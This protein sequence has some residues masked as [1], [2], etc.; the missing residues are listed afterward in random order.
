M[1]SLMSKCK[2]DIKQLLAWVNEAQQ[3]FQGWRADSWEDYE[4]RDGKQ[5]TD[6][7]YQRMAS[8]G[9]KPLTIN[10]TFPIMNLVHG[11]FLN[12]QRDIVA[13][14]RTKKD[15]ELGQVMSEGIQFVVDQ[16][17][18]QQRMNRAVEQQLTA[19]FGC[20]SVGFSNDPRKEKV[21]LFSHNWYSMWWDPY[22]T[23]W[24]DKEECRY[25][26]SAEWTDFQNLI[27]L[28]PEKERE[29]KD[30]F[31]NLATDS[32]VPDVYDE[33]T[34]VEDYKKYLSSSYWVNEERKRVR[35]IEMWYPQ[36]QKTFF[37][38]MPNGRVI[39]LDAID[40]LN[41]EYNVITQAKEVVTANVKKMR[42][43]T[44][45]H[46][47]LL[48]D[49][50]SPYAH[51]EYPFVPFVGYLDRYDFPF[52]IPRQIKEQDME[53]NKRRS[54]A[55][56]LLNSRRVI[57]EQNATE[58][59]Q[60][61]HAEA[62]RPDGFVVMKKGKLDK[63]NIK[64]MADLAPAQMSMMTQSEQEMRE[65]AGAEEN[66]LNLGVAAQSGVALDK[67]QQSSA[68]MTASL[69]QNTRY[70]QRMLGERI[71]SLIQNTWTDE[72]VLRITDRV[73]GTEKFVTLNER[74]VEGTG[75]TVK[76]DITQATFD[77]KVTDRQMTDT[78][79]EKNMDLIFTAINK[80]PQEAVGPLLNLAL[81][82]SDI[83]DKDALLQQ[84]RQSTGVGPLNDDLTQEERDAVA[85]QEQEAKR[86]EQ[87]KETQQADIMTALDQDEK[88]AKAELSRAKA[89]EA[90]AKAAA[91]QQDVDQSGYQIGVQAAQMMKNNQESIKVKKNNDTTKES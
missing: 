62:N 5:W 44:F 91:A 20:M 85:T 41:E 24:M 26:F 49:C 65:I 55:L 42:V 87:E 70:S 22:A 39:D 14:G 11:H 58:D 23:P 31:S 82:L 1:G 3:S 80:S 30:Q 27:A 18:G 40:D 19:G 13:K 16:N 57:I 8:K 51:D 69:L 61:A 74:F 33:G 38:I 90:V 52:G 53:V 75:I 48:Q 9:I 50:P 84:I 64:E 86:A 54:M 78:V 17:K 73:T 36:I 6:A 43:A 34:N 35:P 10:R 29:L 88:R 47:L 28:F 59:E 77:L 67:R 7:D 60:S 46:N 79:R 4:F 63:I 56:T 66:A 89:K 68:T 72:K 76:N 2:T 15:N 32:F 21:A 81:E 45:L 12:N 37:A 25:V 71:S 83:P